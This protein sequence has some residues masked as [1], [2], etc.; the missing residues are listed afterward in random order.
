MS[1]HSFAPIYAGSRRVVKHALLRALSV[2]CKLG[3][4]AGNAV[5]LTFDD[6]P[7]PAVTPAVL[8]RLRRYSARAVF[9]V[10]GS[11]IHRAPWALGEI[12][13][14][15]HVIG[16]HTYHHD[17]VNRGVSGY[18]EDIGSCQ[19]AVVALTGV[20]PSLFRP[21]LGRV[22]AG[23]LRAARRHGLKTLH[24]SVDGGDWSV[25]SPE[26]A[27]DCG[28]RL[29]RAAGPGDVVLLHDDNPCVLTVLD[30]LL[31]DLAARGLDLAGAV[32][33]L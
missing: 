24:W 18:A 13:S 12:L 1:G 28:E 6:G 33:T 8:D 30:V 32:R 16:N 7:H 22:T 20:R 5:L 31:P 10:V 19:E 15:G 27:R 17:Y 29:G 11:R 26:A 23:G 3:T 4:A 25:R 21:P 2:T 14:G 9:F